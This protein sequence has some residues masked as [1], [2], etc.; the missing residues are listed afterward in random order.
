MARY[1]FI[2]RWSIRAP[3]DQVFS[4]IA[5]AST[6][7]RWWPV[8]PTVEVVPDVQ[9]PHIGSRA[10]LAVASA[11]GY[12]LNLEVEIT[13]S[14]PPYYL[15]TLSRGD[16]EGTGTWEFEQKG[17]TTIAT[18]TWI[19]ESHHPLLKMLEPIAKRL[20]EW[21]HNDASEKGHRGLKKLLEK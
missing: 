2:D 17:D 8:Y 1:K 15:N 19:V 13:E 21:S 6:Y 14:N 11:L 4:H 12:R 10:R 20:F 9:P 18:W 5:D 7:P 3:I 16:L